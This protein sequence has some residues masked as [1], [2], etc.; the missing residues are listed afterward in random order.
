MKG[1]NIGISYMGVGRLESKR[2]KP[3]TK[4]CRKQL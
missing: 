4:S 2:E 3:E 1:F